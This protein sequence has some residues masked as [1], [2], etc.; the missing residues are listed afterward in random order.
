[1]G[2]GNG[3]EG[4]YGGKEREKRWVLR[5]ERKQFQDRNKG[6]K[7]DETDEWVIFVIFIMVS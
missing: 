5:H 2:K 7:V 1:M 6:W 3:R 4:N